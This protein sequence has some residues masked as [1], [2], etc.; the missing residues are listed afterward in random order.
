MPLLSR[1]T[2][3]EK[4]PNVVL[5]LADDLGYGD[6]SCYGNSYIRTPNLDRLAAGG[7]RFTD[8]HSSGPV[9]SPT[10][11]GL[12]TG[13]YQQRCGITEVITAAGTR[14]NGLDP[15]T[16][17]TFAKQLKQAGYATGVFGKWHVGYQPKFNPDKHGFDRFR[18]YVSGNVDYF[19]HV[20]Q[21]GFADWWENSKLVPEEGYTTELIT[22]HGIE[23]I[24]A[25][26]NRPFCLYLP[27]EAVHAPYQGPTDRPQRVAGRQYNEGGS[28]TDVKATYKDMIESMDTNIG[29]VLA[30]LK[31][32]GLERDTFVFY[33]SDNGATPRG[34]NGRL[35][36]FKGSLLEC[37]HREPAIAYWPGKIGPGRVCDATTICLD[38]FPT[39]LELAG[40]SAPEN[41]LD[42]MSLLPVLTGKGKIGERTLFWAYMKQRAVRRG[43]W[44]LITGAPGS[45]PSP[46]LFD[47]ENDLGETKDLAQQNPDIIKDLSASLRK[48]EQ[49]VGA[50]S[51]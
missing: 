28:T 40:A 36:G 31:R 42:G 9:C 32:F 38:L 8:F 3:A 7:V 48:W 26:R 22:R 29:K 41:K 50:K 6:M 25:N 45:G 1:L 13:R 12:L 18:G 17:S 24:E 16:Q 27:Y 47:L 21:A 37:G 20:D 43:K 19:S 46:A 34:S 44:K 11:A 10:R 15:A 23:F 35:R 51:S 14:E 5:L 4:K 39:L 33:F 49:D 30:T 2:A